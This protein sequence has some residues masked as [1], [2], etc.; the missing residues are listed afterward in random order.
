MQISLTKIPEDIID[1]DEVDDSDSEGE[2]EESPGIMPESIRGFLFRAVG[3]WLI[4]D[5]MDTSF[6]GTKKEIEALSKVMMATKDFYQYLRNGKEQDFKVMQSLLNRKL[7]TARD[8]QKVFGF[9]WPF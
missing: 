5:E 6:K 2:F 1:I 3:L 9:S 7:E 8:F 4:S